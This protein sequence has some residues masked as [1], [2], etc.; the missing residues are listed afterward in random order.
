MTV[1]EK[2][3]KIF[4]NAGINA[5]PECD[6][7]YLKAIQDEV[8]DAVAE[9]EQQI[10]EERKWAKHW[11]KEATELK[12]RI[13]AQNA[14]MFD[15]AKKRKKLEQRLSEIHQKMREQIIRLGMM[16]A[17]NIDQIWDA[18]WAYGLL[19]QIGK[20]PEFKTRKEPFEWARAKICRF[21]KRED[22]ERELLDGGEQ[23]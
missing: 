16:R 13:E 14:V 21:Q 23:Q 10:T 1:A 20:A 12:D 5:V 2:I 7:D 17:G 6:D 18:G 8:L 3:R 19:A 4:I 15:V 22:S 11:A 9:L